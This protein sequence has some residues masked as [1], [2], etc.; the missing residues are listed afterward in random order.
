MTTSPTLKNR[1]VK[2]AMPVTGSVFAIVGTGV[3]VAY[4]DEPL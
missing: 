1:I 3:D 4:V 2:F